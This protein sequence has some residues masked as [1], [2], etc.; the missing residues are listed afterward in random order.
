[1]MA[2][3]AAY[4]YA[5][6]KLRPSWWLV[7]PLVAA[8]LI[9]LLI[10]IGICGGIGN[11]VDTYRIYASLQQKLDYTVHYEKGPWFRYLLDFLAIA[12]VVFI[13]A[14]IGFFARSEESIRHGRNLALI[15][16]ASGVLLFGQMP[17]VNV[18]LVLFVDMF[19]RLGAAVA[20]TYFAAQSV[21]K[22][23][24]RIFYLAIGLLVMTDAWQF[25]Q[26]FVVG[27][28]Y[29]PTTFLLLRAEGFYDIHPQ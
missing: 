12:P 17:I 27:N 6:M 1:M 21:E 10:E 26:I 4:Y 19:L 18:R 16:F 7:L 25:Y 11:F 3:A 22:W 24:R 14:I 5:A 23:S 15:Y 20:I 8:P 29:S 9:Y 13:A 28:V 2:I